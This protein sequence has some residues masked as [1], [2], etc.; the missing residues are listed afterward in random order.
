MLRAG[1]AFAWTAWVEYWEAATAEANVLPAEP[2][3]DISQEQEGFIAKI[4]AG[5]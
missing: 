3:L 1:L 4:M 2:S 5:R